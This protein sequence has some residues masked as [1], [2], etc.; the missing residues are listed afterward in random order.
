MME[1]VEKHDEIR[2]KTIK[3]D[4]NEENDGIMEKKEIWKTMR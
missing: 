3:N 1:N 4:E 2:K